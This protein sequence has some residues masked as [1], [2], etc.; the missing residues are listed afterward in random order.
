MFVKLCL[1]PISNYEVFVIL[2]RRQRNK[3]DAFAIRINLLKMHSYF[4]KYSKK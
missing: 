1:W 3:Y 2:S 4:L